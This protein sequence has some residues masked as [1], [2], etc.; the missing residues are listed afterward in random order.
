[1]VTARDVVDWVAARAGSFY[2]SQGPER[3][4]WPTRGT[5]C[6]ALC[7]L[8]YRH[9]AGIEI[10]SYTDNMVGRGKTVF[11]TEELSAET[12]IAKLLP[13]DLIF[14]QWKGHSG[15][16]YWDHVEMYAGQGRNWSHG[17]PGMGPQ[18]LDFRSEWNQANY[19]VARRYLEGEIDDMPSLNEI[20]QVVREEAGF[21][22][23][24]APMIN[25]LY[26]GGAE[27]PAT[28][29]GAMER[30]LVKESLGPMLVG[31]LAAIEARLAAMESGV[32]ITEEMVSKAVQKAIESITVTV[33]RAGE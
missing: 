13:G 33:N 23:A 8:A 7:V 1:M 24:G 14:F 15:G 5:D 10:G 4:D 6:S 28:A 25:N 2:Y 29:L 16:P 3:L 18:L 12:A 19:I 26:S 21:Q 20:R 32:E 27:W 22:G 31:R 11:G 30:R 9:V 17:G